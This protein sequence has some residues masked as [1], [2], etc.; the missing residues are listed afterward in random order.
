MTMPLPPNSSRHPATVSRMRLVVNSLAREEC[1]SRW[2]PSSSMSESRV[3]AP[4]EE[5]TLALMSAAQAGDG[6]LVGGVHDF[7]CTITGSVRRR[8]APYS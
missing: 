5:V 2:V 1:S 7:G 3:M 4:I 6:V 8:Q